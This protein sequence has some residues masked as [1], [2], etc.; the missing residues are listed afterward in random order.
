MKVIFISTLYEQHLKNHYNKY[1]NNE[2][3]SYQ[4]QLKHLLNTSLPNITYFAIPFNNIGEEAIPIISNA[5][6]LQTAW[7]KENNIIID[8]NWQFAIAIEQIKKYKPDILFIPS[9]FQYYGHFIKEIKSYTKTIIAYISC[10]M[11]DNTDYTGIDCILTI[12][13]NL[14]DKYHK[15]GLASEQLHYA[16]A[17]QILSQL[18][19]NVEANI[20]ISFIGSLMPTTHSKR[21]R[22]LNFI[23]SNIPIKIW[24]YGLEKRYYRWYQRIIRKFYPNAFISPIEK[25]YLGELWGIDMYST[26]QN[27]KIVFNAHID[28]AEEYIGS[29]RM[30]EVTGIGSLLLSENGRNIKELFEPDKEIITY[31]SEEELLEK[32]KYYLDNEE[33]RKE[34]ALAGQKRTLKE[35]TFEKRAVQLAEIFKKYL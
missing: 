30:Y 23:V 31:S 1:P 29:T 26:L 32:V 16:F 20:D 17:K 22:Y 19:T 34:I 33:K 21:I 4:E 8:E 35:H 12:L 2:K 28:M 10:P 14:I 11:P 18:E 25:Y 24:G 7:A 9:T 5:K 13:P 15:L 3:L 27:S 6:P